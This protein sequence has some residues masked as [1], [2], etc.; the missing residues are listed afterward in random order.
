MVTQATP[1]LP[2]HMV[3]QIKPKYMN[4]TN[5]NYPPQTYTHTIWDEI[6]DDI[7]FSIGSPEAHHSYVVWPSFNAIDARY[8]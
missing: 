5:T 7:S 1:L 2:F 6:E 4:Y 8:G 3:E